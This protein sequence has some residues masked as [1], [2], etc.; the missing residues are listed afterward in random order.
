[1]EPIGRVTSY[2]RRLS[3]WHIEHEQKMKAVKKAILFP[4]H[5][6]VANIADGKDEAVCKYLVGNVSPPQL[7]VCRAL[8]PLKKK[9]SRAKEKLK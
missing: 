2:L 1:M 4:I 7:K 5:Y 6:V 8:R 9:Y 3:A